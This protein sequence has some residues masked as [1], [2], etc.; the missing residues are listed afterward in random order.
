MPAPLPLQIREAIVRARETGLSY[1]EVAATLG[2]CESTV[3][4]VLR[5]RRAR[6]SVAPLTRGGGNPSPIRGA[7]AELL[8]MIISRMPD[9][10]VAELTEALIQE[11]GQ[12]TS[13]SAVVRALRRLGYTRKKSAS[14]PPSRTLRRTANAG[15][16]SA[17]FSL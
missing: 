3:A 11:A 15:E 5:R 7:M 6:G 1:T 16:H 8:H 17:K 9:A 13:R 4:R 2:V 12:S 14:S 10:T